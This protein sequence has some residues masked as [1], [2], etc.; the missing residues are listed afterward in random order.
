MQVSGG[1]LQRLRHL[2]SLSSIRALREAHHPLTL[3]ELAAATGLSRGSVIDLVADLHERG[4]I[5]EVDPVPGG[6]GRPAKRYRFRADAGYALGIDIGV[7][8]ILAVVT[9]LA[10]RTLASGR[11]ALNRHITRSERLDAVSRAVD[12]AL[13]A[14]GLTAQDLWGASIG[15]IGVVNREGQVTRVEELP[16]WAGVDLVGHL[17]R[18]LPCPIIIEN[19]SKLAAL[20]E[21]RLGVAAGVSD[22]VYLHAGRRPGAAIIINGRL[23][24]GFSGATGEVGLMAITGWRTMAGHLENCPVAAGAA[25]DEAAGIVFRAARN[26][27]PEALAAVDRYAH[28]LAL[29]TAAMVLT[30]DPEVVVLGGGF[31]RSADVLLP[32]LLRALEP[33]CVRVPEVRPSTLGEECVALGAAC[34]ALEY[35]DERFFSPEGSISDPAAPQSLI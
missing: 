1:D 3:T 6:M 25:P 21:Q 22:V 7:H 20:A 2:N 18:R 29:G 16:D 17:G 14:G 10:G 15:S 9:D 31:S 35:V 30:L 5:A 26:G 33:H 32:A 19:D 12:A 23:H 28:Y 8:K 24:H 13:V 4:W 27:D 34:L 11:A